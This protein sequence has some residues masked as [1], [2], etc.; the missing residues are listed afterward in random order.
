MGTRF[1]AQLALGD[2][3]EQNDCTDLIFLWV[4][5]RL[6]T[7]PLIHM[8]FLHMLVNII[9]LTPLMERFEAEYGTLNTTALF[10][11]REYCDLGERGAIRLSGSQ[12]WRHCRRHFIYSWTWSFWD[13]TLLFSGRGEQWRKSHSDERAN[14]KYSVWIFLLLGAEAI[15]T[16]RSNP[17]LEYAWSLSQ[18]STLGT[19]G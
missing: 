12:H 19:C 2:G 10:L 13:T 9:C 1:R 15:K 16:Y 6:N 14:D 5:Y 4:V 17:Y 3:I 8:G 11:G 18:C 7:F